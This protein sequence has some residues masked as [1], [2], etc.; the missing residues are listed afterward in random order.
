[1]FDHLQ[2][3][4]LENLNIFRHNTFMIVFS[5]YISILFFLRSLTVSGLYSSV[6]DIFDIP[7]LVNLTFAVLQDNK[8]TFGWIIYNKK[9]YPRKKYVT[10]FTDV[11][12]S[13][14]KYISHQN[15][16]FYKKT[17]RPMRIQLVSSDNLFSRGNNFSSKENRYYTME[18]L[19]LLFNVFFLEKKE[20]S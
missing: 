7:E 13:D 11:T 20:I 1:M 19:Y 18:K 14:Q 8:T 16:Y 4:S 9:K 12:T 6:L 17:K 2:I 3:T 15:K 10:L 5:Q